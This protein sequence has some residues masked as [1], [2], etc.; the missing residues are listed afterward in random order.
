MRTLTRRQWWWAAAFVWVGA[1]VSLSFLVP[2]YGEICQKNEYSGAK[3]CTTYHIALAAFWQIIKATN[4]YSGAITGIATIL[5]VYV[6]YR[7]VYVAHE[8]STTTRAQLRAYVFVNGQKDIP[9]V[10][11]SERGIIIWFV[12]RNSGQTPAY[13][14]RQWLTTD[15]LPNALDAPVPHPSAIANTATAALGPNSELPLRAFHP[16]PTDE[17]IIRLRNGSLTICIWGELTYED[18]FGQPH[19]SKFSYEIPIEKDDRVPG[20]RLARQGNE[21]N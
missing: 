8:Q 3:E 6:T 18:A 1:L 4:D 2:W 5:L 11:D 14:V 10:F 21:A 9:P 17:Q 13:K 12:A 7:L 16:V 20:V 19:Y 15:L